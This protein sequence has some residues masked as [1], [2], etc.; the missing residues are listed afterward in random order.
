M[1]SLRHQDPSHLHRPWNFDLVQPSLFSPP[2]YL[3]QMAMC[4]GTG[5]LLLLRL[6]PS[7][8][9]PAARR[10]IPQEE[11]GVALPAAV[12]LRDDAMPVAVSRDSIYRSAIP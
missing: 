3:L 11:G 12:E 8:V 7:L 5:P 1:A 10:L 9:S 2:F 4:S 6:F